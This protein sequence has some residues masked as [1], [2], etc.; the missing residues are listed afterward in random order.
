MEYGKLRRECQDWLSASKKVSRRLTIS[1]ILRVVKL[2][3]LLFIYVAVTKSVINAQALSPE[4][5]GAS[6]LLLLVTYLLIKIFT[7]KATKPSIQSVVLNHSLYTTKKAKDN[8]WSQ[9]NHIINEGK[10]ILR[11]L[12]ENDEVIRK[13]PVVLEHIEAYVTQ[14]ITTVHQWEVMEELVIYGLLITEK[15]DNKNRYFGSFSLLSAIEHNILD[16]TNK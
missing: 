13:T 11:S 14:D 15:S 5:L 12:A 8:L 6:I 16:G 1:T 9:T 10:L 2:P 7:K 4:H 3:T